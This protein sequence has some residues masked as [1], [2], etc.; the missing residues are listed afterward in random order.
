MA[1]KHLQTWCKAVSTEK[2]RISNGLMERW[3]VNIQSIGQLSADLLDKVGFEYVQTR[4]LNQ[5]KLEV[6]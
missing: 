4:R 6:L 2:E 3:L 1:Q 5:D